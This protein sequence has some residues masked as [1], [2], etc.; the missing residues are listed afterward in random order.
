MFMHKTAVLMPLPAS[1]LDP[2]WPPVLFHGSLLCR[3]YIELLIGLEALD[4]GYITVQN[5]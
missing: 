1:V 5:P 4:Q 3:S 2:Y